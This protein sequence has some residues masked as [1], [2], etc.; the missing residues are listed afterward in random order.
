[1][2]LRPWNGARNIELT[3]AHSRRPSRNQGLAVAGV[4]VA[5]GAITLGVL[6]QGSP[7]AVPI[8]SASAG[9]HTSGAASAEPSAQP[10]E[11]WE[12]V[13]LSPLE[14]VATLE[15][16]A[17]DEAGIPPNATFTLASLT[18][19]PARTLADRLEI[20]PAA[21]FTVRPSADPAT[22]VIKPGAALAAGDTYRFVLRTVDGTVTGSWAFRV[23]GPVAVISTIPGDAT[24]GVPVRT[25]VELTFDQEAVADMADHFS[26]EPAVKGTFE[27]HG[28]TQVFVPSE[29]APATTYTVTLRKGLARTGTDLSLPADVVF[30]FE[31][32][33]PGEEQARLIFAREAIESGP[34]EPL[35]VA[36]QSIRPYLAGEQAPAPTSASLR[37]YRLPSFAAA[38]RVLTNFLEAPHWTQYSDPLMPTDGLPVVAAFSGPLE[39]LADSIL[40]LNVPMQLDAG[41]YILEIP[42]TRRSQAFLQVTPVST[43]VSVLSDRTVVWVNDV[44]THRAIEGATVAVGAAEP[45][46]MSDPDGLAIGTT[47][48]ALLPP[49]AG[50]YANARS[51]ILRVT[52]PTGGVVLVPF[53]VRGDRE[54]YRGEWSES[55][56][57]ADETYWAMLYT[58]R[59]VYRRTD[60]IEV[61][62]YVRGRDDGAV[63]GQ[64]QIRLVANGASRDPDVSAVGT[65]E[66]HP[67]ADGAFIASLPIVDLPLDSYE[68]Q[69]VV[70]GRVVVSRWVDVTVI[71][72][73]PYQLELTSDPTA[74]ITGTPVTLTANATFFDGTP[75]ASLGVT[76]SGDQTVGEHRATTDATGRASV[77]LHTPT[78]STSYLDWRSVEVRPA[79]PESADIS[80]SATTVIFP[81]AYHLDATGVVAGGQ[82]RITGKVTAID[83]AK[84]RRALASGSWDGNPPGAPVPGATVKAAV[85]ELI[86][87]RRQVGTEYDFV[88]KIVRPVYEYDYENKS[89]GTLS[90]DSGRDGSIRLSMPVPNVDHQYQVLLTTHDDSGRIQQ[91]TTWVSA[92]EPPSPGEGIQFVTDDGT[93]ASDVKYGIGDKVSWRIVDDGRDLPS[94]SD[95]R[96]LY[97]VAQR[98]LRAAVVTDTPRFRHTFAAGDAPGIFVMGIRFTGTTY[99]PKAASWADFDTAQR[100]IRV[101]ISADRARYRPGD[102]ATLSVRTTDPAGSPVAATVVLQAVDQKLFAM[103][104]AVVPRPLDDLYARVDS[105]IVR[106]TATH[107]IPSM[108]GPEGEGGDTS[109]G[110]GD[111]TDFK[112]TLLFRELHTDS[113]GRAS[114]TVRLSDDLTSWHVSAGAVTGGLAAGVGELLVPVGLP[115]FVEVTVADTYQASDQPKVQVRAFGDA[116]HAGDSV[117]FT[118]SSPSLGLAAT[119]VH[120]VAFEPVSVALPALSL[121]A[122]SITARAVAPT[123]KDAAGKPLSD[124]L[125]RS[126]EVVAT[127]LT[128]GTTA[129]GRVADG[130]PPMPA[131]A[132]RATWTFTDAGRGRLVTLLSALSDASSVRLDRSIAQS[133]ARKILVATFG[134]DAA[135]FPP[136]DLDPS[137]YP[138]G[139][140]TSDGG[141]TTQGGVALLPYGSLDPWLAARIALMAP[142]ALPA[143]TLGNTLASIRDFP[144]TKRDLQIA[145][146]AGLAG[147]GRTGPRRPA[148]SRPPTR[149]HADR[150]D[151]PRPWLRGRRRRLECRHHRARPSQDLR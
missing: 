121:G 111:R 60:R 77:I 1:M 19:E 65:A 39:P 115:F 40:A 29:L 14:A 12:P 123:R 112:D 16:S 103:G 72:K 67:G 116:L 138:I 142:E 101:V 145:A 28:R 126:F 122:Q 18:G 132:E 48:R 95:D 135:S 80:A 25:G 118:V 148:R 70:D 113:A 74:V 24:T 141:T 7:P 53:N 30:R 104:G 133:N 98:G 71:R 68:V 32:E 35:V 136:A 100:A 139:T 125:T 102:T 52:S 56:G 137:V 99:A 151:L 117:D 105:G 31:T 146:L 22:A 57:S 129:Y 43:W 108:A 87:I 45:F 109:G 59:E 91:L 83:L 90:V 46:A 106:L 42:G 23:R 75:V 47:P 15:P 33:G 41:W 81:S 13:Q 50:G 84:V 73:P 51:P 64:V 17:N 8:A 5:I 134:R 38:S 82:L 97:V 27:R 150:A 37:I 85:T 58:D 92:A 62:G 10:A 79:G 20:S 130:L 149:P 119:M 124:G 55:F 114:T 120:G 4:L 69:V 143:A 3:T 34:G 107:Q 110:G 21:A 76:L 86:P 140:A 88:E 128:A 63:P 94:G 54:A 147:T 93:F 131:G 44:V 89:L 11:P 61:W 9:A 96:Y 127:R 78:E 2:G 66:S 6:L 36:V 144:T 49:A 26:I